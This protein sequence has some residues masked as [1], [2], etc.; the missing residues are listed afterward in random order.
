[1]SENPSQEGKK[2]SKSCSTKN[3]PQKLTRILHFRCTFE[4]EKFLQ[5]QAETRNLS[6]SDF[7]RARVFVTNLNTL[8]PDPG[9][10]LETPN[11]KKEVHYL[12]SLRAWWETYEFTRLDLCLFIA[13]ELMFLF[14]TLL[15]PD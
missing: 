8:T 7:L 12:N 9:Q 3:G 4:E 15:L 6:L 10:P 14:V 5:K 2:D 13:L 1:M 11:K